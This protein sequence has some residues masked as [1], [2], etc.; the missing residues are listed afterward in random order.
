M[1]TGATGMVGGL[2][3]ILFLNNPDV[4]RVTVIGRRSTKVEHPKLCEVLHDDFVDFSAAADFFENQDVVL[5]CLGAYTSAVPDDTFR[6]I[7]VDYTLVD[8]LF[9]TSLPG[10]VMSTQ[11]APRPGDSGLRNL[12]PSAK[13]GMFKFSSRA[14]QRVTAL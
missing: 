10:R 9:C 4:A 12:A 13:S 7:T 14:I 3:L 8:G 11:G 6:R 5:Y 1:I 2:T